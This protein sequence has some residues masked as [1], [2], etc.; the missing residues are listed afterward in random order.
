[1]NLI[2]VAPPAEEPVSLLGAKQWA[3][4][5]IADDDDLI[6]SLIESAR[7]EAEEYTQ[8]AFIDQGWELKLDCFP[9][10]IDLPKAPLSSVT[11]IDY[12]DSD[13]ATQA[14]TDFVVTGSNGSGRIVPAYGFS[15]PITRSQVDAVTITFV[16]GYGD[17]AV[18]PE[19]IKSAINVRVNDM[20]VNREE[21]K[22]LDTFRNLLNPFR[23]S[24]G[25]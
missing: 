20:Y 3:R 4:V 19:A 21:S 11:S 9:S 7:I 2:L 6:D 15:W 12:V 22:S 14:F 24:M 1:M 10:A 5:E 8:R 17:A 23:V 18:V 16:A 13:G 25:V